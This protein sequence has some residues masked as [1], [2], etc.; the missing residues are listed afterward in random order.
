MSGAM[1]LPGS[2]GKLRSA[3]PSCGEMGPVSVCGISDVEQFGYRRCPRFC[4]TPVIWRNVPG[5][6]L[7]A[8]KICRLPNG[9]I[10]IIFGEI[11]LVSARGVSNVIFVGL[12]VFGGRP[13]FWRNVPGGI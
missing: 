11:S 2:E 13:A 6:I 8:A 3:T 4:R 9:L 12:P 7:R 10:P 1:H 5:R